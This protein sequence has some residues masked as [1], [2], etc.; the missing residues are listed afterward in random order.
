[1]TSISIRELKANPG[2]VIASGRPTIVTQR[3]R[4]VALLTPLSEEAALDLVVAHASELVERMLVADAAIA[5]GEL[6][7]PLEDVLDRLD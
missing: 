2:R 4:V 6:G 3:G 1:M 7:S 5:R